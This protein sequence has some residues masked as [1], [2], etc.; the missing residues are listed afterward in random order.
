VVGAFWSV[1]VELG[2]SVFGFRLFVGRDGCGL[3]A[4]VLFRLMVDGFFGWVW[5]G[6][7]GV[8]NGFVCWVVCGVR[9]WV[10]FDGLTAGTALIGNRLLGLFVL[11]D[12]V[13]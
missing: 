7:C 3:L 10:V 13:C 4:E 8:R 11:R 2:K 6:R 1:P 12:W 9:N 5:V